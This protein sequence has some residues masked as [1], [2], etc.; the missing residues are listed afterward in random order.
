M[1]ILF[2]S[3]PVEF[4]K[5]LQKYH[6]KKT[7]L[8][9]GFYKKG[10]G[11]ISITW[12][13]AVDQ[14]LCFGWI[15][16]VRKSIDTES[17]CNRFTPRKPNSIWSAINIK[18]VEEMMRQG[19][20]TPAGLKAFDAKKQHKMGMYAHETEPVIL[21]PVFEK[22]LKKNKPAWVFFNAQPPSYKKITIHWI[23]GAKQEKTRVARLEKTILYSEQQKRVL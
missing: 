5:W 2:F 19:L 10:S 14:A 12:S 20:M 6:Q 18:K 3:T 15:D 8:Y 13:Q 9:V 22:Q 21:S 16:S 4:R 23:M 11:K 1:E 7:E 17:Y